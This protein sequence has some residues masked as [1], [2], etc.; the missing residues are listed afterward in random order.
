MQ[1]ATFADERENMIF[2]LDKEM[3]Q[4]HL[5]KFSHLV[6]NSLARTSVYLKGNHPKIFNECYAYHKRLKAVPVY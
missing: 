1:Y 3:Q 4:T 6:K 5:T 2:S